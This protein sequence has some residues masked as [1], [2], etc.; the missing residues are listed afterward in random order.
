MPDRRCQQRA[1]SSRS[2]LRPEKRIH[3]S[4][5]REG[6]GGVL[7]LIA[8]VGMLELSGALAAG[9]CGRQACARAEKDTSPVA[10]SATAHVVPAVWFVRLGG[11]NGARATMTWAC[12]TSFGSSHAKRAAYASTC[13]RPP[14][15]PAWPDRS[16]PDPRN[17]P[18]LGGLNCG[19]R[20]QDQT[21]KE[22]PGERSGAGVSEC[23]ES[24]VLPDG[25][26]YGEPM[27]GQVQN[28]APK[29]RE[30]HAHLK[31]AEINKHAGTGLGPLRVARGGRAPG[32]PHSDP[33]E[34]R[35]KK[36]AQPRSR[37]SRSK[38]WIRMPT[39]TELPPL[40]DPSLAPATRAYACRLIRA[41]L[42]LAVAGLV[43]GAPQP[44]LAAGDEAGRG[45]PRRVR[46]LGERHA[47]L[48][49]ARRPARGDR[50]TR[51][52]QLDYR[53]RRHGRTPGRHVLAAVQERAGAR[54]GGGCARRAA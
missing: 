16:T 37:L 49:V 40:A 54:E 7:A 34:P 11:S 8:L 31:D 44:A 15:P 24:C 4:V 17:V 45:P 5:A 25:N 41:G 10:A 33:M 2:Q 18:R 42:A 47:A 39:L 12:A 19:D 32:V 48:C 27:I 52:Q 50:R 30:P 3:L 29:K 51:T 35:V 14:A 1:W 43:T 28:G 53:A 22:R 9:S 13:R 36:R 20:L 38:P 26:T 46:W 21:R 6:G 23:G